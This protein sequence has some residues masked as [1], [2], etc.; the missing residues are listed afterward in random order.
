MPLGF[1]DFPYVA[2]CAA[3]AV[4]AGLL[5]L[6]PLARLCVVCAV[7]GRC[8][9][10]LVGAYCHTPGARREM[11]VPLAEI[12]DLRRKILQIQSICVRPMRPYSLASHDMKDETISRRNRRTRRRK[13]LINQINLCETHTPLQLGF[14]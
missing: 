3:L 10:T 11:K 5:K 2:G 4:N 8:D 13:N 14:A 12:A 1:I 7:C 6:Q 9:A